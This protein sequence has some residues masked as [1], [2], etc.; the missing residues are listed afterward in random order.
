MTTDSQTFLDY[1]EIAG[2]GDAE[3]QYQTG[4]CYAKGLGVTQSYRQAAHY[5]LMAAKQQHPNAQ[6]YLGTLFEKGLDVPKDLAKAAQCYQ[7]A[8]NQDLAEAKVRLAMLY[9]QGQGVAHDPKKAILLFIQAA[10]QGNPSAQYNL[11]IAYDK[12]LGGL[13]Q[14]SEQ[15]FFWYQ[16]AANQQHAQA[17]QKI[18]E[19]RFAQ[20][21]M[22][23]APPAEVN[24]QSESQVDIGQM[25]QQQV[26]QQQADSQAVAHHA[27]DLFEQ[28]SQL[29]TQD[30]HQAM[31]RFAEAATAG[32][33]KAQYNLG[34]GY[35]YGLGGLAVDP[36][37]ALGW[38]KQSADTGF[39]PAYFVL[40]W[41][42]QVGKVNGISMVTADNS[43]ATGYYEMAGELG[44]A[45][46]QYFLSKIYASGNG[47]VPNSDTA[48]AWLRQSA[49]QGYNRAYYELEQLVP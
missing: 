22:P 41:L 29:V 15:A 35:L 21:L 47:V 28:G 36:E 42:Y 37:K 8:V 18:H 32:Q 46:A 33:A 6:M 23:I 10:N 49:K 13:T 26:P 1:A 30:I 25:V 16:Q 38:L 43:L 27:D 34:L 12:G 45:Q 5:W 31:Q 24:V 7:S 40:G 20:L 19:P 14:N 9:M 3:A 4:C 39:R 44:H 48:L 11:G 2:Q 17:L